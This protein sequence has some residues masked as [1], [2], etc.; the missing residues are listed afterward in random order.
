MMGLGQ[1]ALLFLRYEFCIHFSLSFPSTVMPHL[2]PTQQD[3]QAV[4]HFH[5]WPLVDYGAGAADQL[6]IN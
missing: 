2:P 4:A 3:R 1:G 6:D 5:V